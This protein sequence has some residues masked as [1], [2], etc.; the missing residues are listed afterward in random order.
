MIKH[1]G[2]KFQKFFSGFSFLGKSEKKRG[3]SP[4]VLFFQRIISQG[5]IVA[6]S[7]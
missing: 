7:T 5:K 4:I 3:Y 2:E 1:S 6:V